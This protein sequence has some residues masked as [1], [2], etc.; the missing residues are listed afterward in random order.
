LKVED[1]VAGAIFRAAD[2]EATARRTLGEIRRTQQ[3]RFVREILQNLLAVPDVVAAREDF[4]AAG[5]QF[6]G[7]ARRDAEAGGGIFAIGDA[8]IN[9]ALGEDVREPV[10]NDLA[11][12]RADDVADE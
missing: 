6:V 12:G 3:A 5:E 9:F 4:D 1:G 7:D 11:A 8:E 10:V 2:I